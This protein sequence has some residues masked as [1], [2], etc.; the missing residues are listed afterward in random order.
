MASLSAILNDEPADAVH[1]ARSEPRTL[2]KPPLQIP[3]N[4]YIHHA[5]AA[6][7]PQSH[8]SRRLSTTENEAILALAALSSTGSNPP[9]SWPTKDVDQTW[10]VNTLEDQTL[11]SFYDDLVHASRSHIGDESAQSIPQPISPE[12]TISRRRSSPTLEQYRYISPV[13]SRQSFDPSLQLAPLNITNS[14]PS[15]TRHVEHVTNPPINTV[16]EATQSASITA[17]PSNSTIQHS[18]AHSEATIDNQDTITPVVTADASVSNAP[19]SIPIIQPTAQGILLQQ[20]SSISNDVDMTEA[21]QIPST[22]PA[23]PISMQRETEI[24]IKPELSLAI[25]SPSR[26]NSIPI[27]TTEDIM[28]STTARGIKR[29]APKALPKKTG[30]KKGRPAKKQKL[31]A[32]VDENLPSLPKP[33]TKAK[34][35]GSAKTPLSATA[36][37][38]GS[39]PAPRSARGLSNLDRSS[40][41]PVVEPENDD[42]SEVDEEEGTSD[43]EGNVYC[44]CRKPDTGSVMIGCDGKC[45]DWYHIK[46]VGVKDQD[47]QLIDKYMCPVCE[48]K[49]IGVTTWKRMCR[50]EGC[51]KPARLAK[52]D[53]EPSK[54][55][56][57][58]CGVAFFQGMMS[59]TREVADEAVKKDGR[60]KK[61]ITQSMEQSFK[62]NDPLGGVISVHELK[63]LVTNA[64]QLDQF[65]QLGKGVLS[66]PATPSPTNLSSN[67]KHTLDFDN[68]SIDDRERIL[69]IEVMKTQLR[70][71]HTLLK[72]QAKL[73]NMIK[74]SILRIAE[75]KGIKPKDMCFYD[76]RIRWNLDEIAAWRDTSIGKEALE[77]GMLNLSDA[78]QNSDD[79][80]ERDGLC[81]K[82][83]CQKHKEWAT[84]ALETNRSEMAETV[85]RMR[86]IDR[87]EKELRER[88]TLK[89]RQIHAGEFGGTVEH[90][91]IIKGRRKK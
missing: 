83:K 79:E 46:C 19:H 68:L 78:E 13:Q 74:Q 18:P 58:E 72:D 60:C 69:E 1:P 54:Y 84:I 66:P 39:S 47:R 64:P 16:N 14:H 41:T 86:N 71:R 67:V 85:E 2:T 31:S 52:K 81:S 88:A 50:R 53:V 89:A 38:H 51:R 22:G 48:E 49:G 36:T 4:P 7:S 77:T 33:N 40:A 21:S 27:S 65:K 73:I 63:S 24:M 9:T 5:D 10:N 12:L 87:E 75:T 32:T 23:P 61:S 91:F 82:K 28:P 26:E 37:P 17:V 45:D 34:V 44:I 76:D 56:S 30:G 6:S 3:E 35:K 8:V 90:H 25:P 15:T 42:G 59:N 29:P 43:Q 57:D 70:K 80:L 11:S 20:E 62:A 55:C